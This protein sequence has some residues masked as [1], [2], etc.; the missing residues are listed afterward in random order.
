[1]ADAQ[2]FL[3]NS[4][5]GFLSMLVNRSACRMGRGEGD[6]IRSQHLD[7]YPGRHCRSI[8]GRGARRRP[9][10]PVFVFVRTLVAADHRCNLDS[11]RVAS[12]A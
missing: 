5:V 6:P 3:G 1:M 7:Q 8:R 10:L 11:V 12:R 2:G 9:E 4:G